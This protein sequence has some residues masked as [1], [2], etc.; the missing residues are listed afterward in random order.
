[1]L[2]FTVLTSTLINLKSY[3][4][5]Y[6][7][8]IIFHR[9]VNLFS[10]FLGCDQVHI[11]F[12]LDFCLPSHPY[13]NLLLLKLNPYAVCNP[14][15]NLL[16]QHNFTVFTS[17][18]L[19]NFTILT[20]TLINWKSYIKYYLFSIISHR[21]V[22]LFSSFLGCDQVH[23]IFLLDFCLPSHPYQNFLNYSPTHKRYFPS[24]NFTPP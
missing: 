4:K 5:S 24:T 7:F 2:N 12:L 22:N 18:Y 3:I 9:L 1:M 23:L 17:F 10:S 14:N 21:L 15:F 8:I 6:L 11:I 13:Q 19:L 20:S 16:F